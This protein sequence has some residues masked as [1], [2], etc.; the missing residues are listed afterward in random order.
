MGGV[1]PNLLAFAIGVIILSV[2]LGVGEQ[3]LTERVQ[4][5]LF[6]RRQKQKVVY[7]TAPRFMDD[8][9]LKKIRREEQL[10][11]KE[12]SEQK[13]F[14]PE[15]DEKNSSEKAKKSPTYAKS[16]KLATSDKSKA[17]KK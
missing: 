3:K 9:D 11:E 13:S 12:A 14:E 4:N 7:S 16:V 10:K 8:E 5:L 1:Y 17:K 15:K 6:V 2:L